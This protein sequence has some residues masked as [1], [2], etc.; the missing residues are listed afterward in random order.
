MET[1]IT[2][3]IFNEARPNGATHARVLS[4]DYVKGKIQFVSG[5]YTGEDWTQLESARADIVEGMTGELMS[6]T[7]EQ[8]I[9]GIQTSI[10]AAY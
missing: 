7:P 1:F 5:F 6:Y 8:Q 3:I 9:A 4:V 10:E 2:E